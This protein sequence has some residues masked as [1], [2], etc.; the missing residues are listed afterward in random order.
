MQICD[1]QAD[2]IQVRGRN[3]TSDLRD[4]RPFVCSQR[5]SALFRHRWP[6][7]ASLGLSLRRFRVLLSEVNDCQKCLHHG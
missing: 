5:G 1:T 4:L 3:L 6:L 7:N 2:R